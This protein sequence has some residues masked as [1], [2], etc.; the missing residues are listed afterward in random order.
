MQ[1]RNNL[2]KLKLDYDKEPT[3]MITWTKWYKPE[4]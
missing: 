1:E 2:I 3:T 4:G